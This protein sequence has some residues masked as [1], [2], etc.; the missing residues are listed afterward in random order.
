M[1]LAATADELGPP[2]PPAELRAAFRAAAAEFR[3]PAEL[4]EAVSAAL[5]G[6][7]VSYH[8]GER[9]GVMGLPAGDKIDG[10]PER[11]VRAAAHVLSI[12]SAADGLAAALRKYAGDELA[13]VAAGYFAILA[14]RSLGTDGRRG[15]RLAAELLCDVAQ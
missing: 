8:N 5:T 15:I 9:A 7:D 3:L 13:A 4:L 11:H 12:W 1:E 14:A 10:G 6:Y 2:D